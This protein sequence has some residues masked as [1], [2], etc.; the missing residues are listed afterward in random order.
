MMNPRDDPAFR[1]VFSIID[2]IFPVV[3]TFDFTFH[4]LPS[5]ER[6]HV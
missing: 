2:F 1:T 4:D 6:T 3:L 5:K